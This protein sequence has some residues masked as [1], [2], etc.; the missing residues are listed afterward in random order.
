MLNSNDT[1][2]FLL[3]KSKKELE[4][5]T[6]YSKIGDSLE[7]SIRQLTSKLK[8]WLANTNSLLDIDNFVKIETRYIHYKQKLARLIQ[9]VDEKR[10]KKK[11]ASKSEVRR[12]RRVSR[13]WTGL[14]LE[15]IKV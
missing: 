7:K 6:V 5:L 13:A 2:D 11:K 9:E 8:D 1:P 3:N 10:T 4:F 15:H 12:V 14:M